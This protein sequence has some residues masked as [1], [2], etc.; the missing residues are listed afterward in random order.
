MAKEILFY[1]DFNSASAERFINALEDN[2]GNEIVVR[3]NS[4]GGSP[5]DAF[6]TIAKLSE[7]KGAKK[8][9]VD[10]KAYSMAAFLISYFDKVECLDVTEFLIHRAAYASWF[11]ND[12]NYMTPAMW[13]NLDRINASLRKSLEA[14]IDVAK[15]EALK[16]V[17]LDEV[18]DNKTRVDVFLDASEAKEIGLV[19]EIKTITPEKKVEINAISMRLAAKYNI[20]KEIKEVN[21]NNSQKP[22]VAMTIE[23]LK[24]DHP[25]VYTAAINAGVMQ[26]RD[27]VGA[28]LTFVD[29]DAEAVSKGIKEGSQLSATQMAEFTRKSFSKQALNDITVD[30]ARTVETEEKET[31]TVAPEAKALE[32]F[33]KSVLAQFKKD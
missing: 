32:D 4:D 9:K 6:G 25:E 1:N 5:E 33:K 14:K 15:F 24:A 19:D 27:R 7:H 31:E 29:V 23:K 3:L 11:E 21:N 10:G 22:S 2:A 26:E 20:D 30:A 17:T 8:L 12:A 18:F 16:G 28:F 13:E